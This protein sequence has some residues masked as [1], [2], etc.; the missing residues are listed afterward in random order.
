LTEIPSNHIDPTDGNPLLALTGF[1][2]PHVSAG[3]KPGPG[4]SALFAEVPFGVYSLKLR[5]DR[6]FY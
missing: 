1:I 5:G 3:S 2:P 6:S 4:I